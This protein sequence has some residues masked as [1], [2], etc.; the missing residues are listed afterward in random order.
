VFAN[1]GSGLIG[2]SGRKTASVC[3][4]HAKET[5]R[6]IATDFTGFAFILFS[7]KRAAKFLKM[8]RK[9]ARGAMSAELL[10]LS[11]LA[12]IDDRLRCGIA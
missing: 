11:S 8:F 10:A 2:N 3:D 7:G 6:N 5:I 1:G 9:E 12:V 4:K